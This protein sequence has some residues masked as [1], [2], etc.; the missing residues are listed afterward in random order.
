MEGPGEMFRVA[1][2][3]LIVAGLA[4]D[5]GPQTVEPFR[6]SVNVDLVVLHPT[7][8]DG[9]GQFA[10]D[11]HEQDFEVYEDGVRQSIKLVPARGRSGYRGTGGRSQQQHAA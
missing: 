11:L 4:G 8:R 3:F 7:V 10:S 1:L 9:K 6:I 5:G 2:P